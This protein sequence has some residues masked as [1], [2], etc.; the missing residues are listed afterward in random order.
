MTWTGADL[1]K[2]YVLFTGLSNNTGIAGKF[3]CAERASAGRLTVP[4]MVVS[5]LPASGTV[6][7]AGQTVPIG[8][9]QLEFLS[10]PAQ[11]PIRAI[12]LDTGSFGY[13]LSTVRIVTVQ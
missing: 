13:S 11:N 5:T 2:Q 3:V 6:T 7:V 10:L 12:G 1:D 4:A 8:W 9:L